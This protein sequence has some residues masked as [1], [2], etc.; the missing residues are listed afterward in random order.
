MSFSS[1]CAECDPSN[2]AALAPITTRALSAAGPDS[3]LQGGQAI[4]VPAICAMYYAGTF[5]AALS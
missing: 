1:G 4:R 2:A 5:Y 3:N